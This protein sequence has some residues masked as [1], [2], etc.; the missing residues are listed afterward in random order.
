MRESIM[1][2][3]RF[4]L[5]LALCLA[6]TLLAGCGR[7]PTQEE[8]PAKEGD[9]DVLQI[10][11]G[12]GPMATY[13]DLDGLSQETLDS[14]YETL[15]LTQES[16]ETGASLHITETM[17]DST[18]LY[19]AFTLT[20]PQTEDS[21]PNFQAALLDGTGLASSKLP[22]PAT[23]LRVA[24]AGDGSFNCLAI[25]DWDTEFL[26]AGEAISL[27]VERGE[28]DPS[29]SPFVLAITWTPQKLAPVQSA[30]LKNE[31]GDTVGNALLSPLSLKL[32]LKET[33]GQSAEAL[34]NSITLLDG[35]G[36][37]LVVNGAFTLSGS[38]A[39]V[40]GGAFFAPVEPSAVRTIQVG[41]YTAEFS[42]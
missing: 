2:K 35:K 17:G 23:E 1:F 32:S 9:P 27:M 33:G 4:A 14:C 8:P 13:L 40:G 30:T 10:K 42:Q 39:V 3:K 41:N 19:V 37:S 31:G 24:E 7:E 5:L 36:D 15:D 16:P 12:L 22:T 25:F 20:C 29:G 6:A 26:S 34:S 11:T 21:L 18:L 38:S 28:E